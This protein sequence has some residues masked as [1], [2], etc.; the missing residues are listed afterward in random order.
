MRARISL[1]PEPGSAEESP[2]WATF[3]DIALAMLLVLLLFIRAQ[4]LHYQRVFVLEEIARRKLAV[5]EQLRALGGPAYGI[6]IEVLDD[7]DLQQRIRVG[8]TGSG[9]N[10]STLVFRECSEELTP[11]GRQLL[12]ALGTVLGQYQDYF[13]SVEVEGH[14]DRQAPTGQ[15]CRDSGIEDNWQL[16]ARR[17]TEVVRVFSGAALVS[18]NKL[19]SVGKGQFHPLSAPQDTMAVALER[20][21]RIE[22]VLRYS[23]T[24][25]AGEGSPDA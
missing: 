13:S 15:L 3:S 16:S 11:G 18:D 21:R 25:I 12:V 17:A 5:A 22:V 9:T 10:S 14:A 2:H 24:G 1:S 23:D 7:D 6:R 19:S 4:F 20:D 8:G